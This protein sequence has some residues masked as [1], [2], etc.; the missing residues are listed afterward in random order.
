ML[1]ARIHVFL[2]PEV[3]DPQGQAIT[4]SLHSLGY[5]NVKET[6]LS[7]YIEILFEDEDEERVRLQT[8]AIC[9]KLLANP[10]TEKYSFELEVVNPPCE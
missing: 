1:K 7:K 6:R 3:L 4:N 10:N 8:D 5:H 9:D 2:K